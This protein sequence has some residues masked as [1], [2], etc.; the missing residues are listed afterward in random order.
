LLSDSKIGPGFADE[1]AR[2]NLFGADQNKVA[3]TFGF[4]LHHDRISPGRNGRP[5]KNTDCFGRR[6]R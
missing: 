1:I 3:F 4:F 6:E 2:R 5:G